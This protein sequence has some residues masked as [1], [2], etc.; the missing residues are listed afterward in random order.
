MNLRQSVDRRLFVGMGASQT[1]ETV[2]LR[3]RDVQSLTH[4]N[5]RMQN[6]QNA[7]LLLKCAATVRIPLSSQSRPGNNGRRVLIKKMH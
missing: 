2:V 6:L 3:I 1:A 4:D 5:A 7:R